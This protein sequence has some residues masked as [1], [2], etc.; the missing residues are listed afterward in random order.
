ML[1]LLPGSGHWFTNCYCCKLLPT[2][3]EM[4]AVVQSARHHGE[5]EFSRNLVQ[6][7]QLLWTRCCAD[8]RC[9]CPESNPGVPPLSRKTTLTTTTEEAP[10]LCWVICVLWDLNDIVWPLIAHY[11]VRQRGCSFCYTALHYL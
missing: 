4:S 3:F 6:K 9:C 1:W 10:S 5:S 2:H 11:C 7:C 8:R